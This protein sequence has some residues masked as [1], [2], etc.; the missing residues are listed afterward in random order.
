M[1]KYIDYD[2]NKHKGLP[3]YE[4]QSDDRGPIIASI[5]V[6]SK[7]THEQ[8][9]KMPLYYVVKESD[10]KRQKT[11]TIKKG[12][13]DSGHHGHGGLPGVWGGSTSSGRQT[14]E[15]PKPKATQPRLPIGKPKATLKPKTERKIPE[16]PGT[17][18]ETQ[19][20]I[21]DYQ[22]LGKK[23]I[24]ELPEEKQQAIRDIE[25]KIKAGIPTD[26]LYKDE[27]GE[28]TS[29]RQQIHD[30]IVNKIMSEAVP[31]ETEPEVIITGGLPG[32][33]KSTVL[34]Q[35]GDEFSNH[36]RVDSDQ[37][38]SMLPEYEGWNATLLHEESSEISATI[39]NRSI[40]GN[41][42]VIYDATLKTESSA[43]RLVTSFEDRGYKSKI[44]FTQVPMETAMTR[45]V[46]RFFGPSKRYVP[47][48]YLATH[49]LKNLGTLESLKSVSDSW[50][51]WD[52]SVH[53]EAP[54]LIG[55]SDG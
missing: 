30:D 11:I 52:N 14:A 41:Y 36:V 51:L 50:E 27:N 23:I 1:T 25:A 16:L 10:T 38:K 21:S 6:K 19:E 45:A 44:I 39:I 24:S 53:G 35:R 34:K 37:I 47:L 5:I 33:G 32:S 54:T 18:E 15:K 29:E 7:A 40:E 8:A 55:K 13:K 28:W 4:I 48:S 9:A 20:S 43:K 49:D 42:N 46:N 2:P 12:G 3:L 31:V 17:P 26:K 22:E